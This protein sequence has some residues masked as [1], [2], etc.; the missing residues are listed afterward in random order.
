MLTFPKLP[1]QVRVLNRLGRWLR[2]CGIRLVPFEPAELRRIAVRRAGLRDFAADPL[3]IE[4]LEV[5]CRS[6]ETDASLTLAGRVGIRDYVVHAL[7]NRLRYVHARTREPEVADVELEPPIIVIGLPRSGTTLLHH[8]LSH[9]PRARALQFW[10][11]MEPIAGAGPDRRR[12][13]LA[14]S[15]AGIKRMD[16][17]I[18]GKHHFDAD[19]PEECMLLLDTTLV[20]LSFWVFAPVHEYLRWLRR[21]DPR[22]GY[23]VY[24]WY[25]Q[26][27]QRETPGRRLV[28]KAPAHTAAI[29]ALLLAIPNARLVQIHRDPAEVV[30]SLH[31]L[32]FSLHAMV[33]DPVD[34]PRMTESNM[35]HLEHLVATTE[36]AHAAG[37]SW[38]EVKYGDLVA[39]PLACVRD[40]YARL[41][42]PFDDEH[43]RRIEEYVA[44]RPKD[45]F[46][47]HRY[48][49]EDFGS[50]AAALRERF[51]GYYHDHCQDHRQDNR[52]AE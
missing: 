44:Q 35:A 28:L 26:R 14:R 38:V 6:L 1:P 30:P 2:R 33:A 22:E 45:K 21:Q 10:E 42:L 47:K 8:L 5:L 15:L 34:I 51:A 27:F 11:L 41:D 31:S 50:T 49:P 20:S 16:R 43:A 19:N 32:I 24:R 29:E 39:D 4:G 52:V 17:D 7:V 48:G 40:I 25:L 3:F 46:G 12:A 36:R 23:R 13:D 18:D 9:D 37:H